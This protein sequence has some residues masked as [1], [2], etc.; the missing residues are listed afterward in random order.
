MCLLGGDT[1][2]RFLEP[3]TLVVGRGDGIVCAGIHRC[4]LRRA[5][6]NSG[7]CA[8]RGVGWCLQEGEH[9]ARGR[10]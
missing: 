2:S 7:I 3:V 10:F 8:A 9:A 6:T 5:A 4:D 1:G